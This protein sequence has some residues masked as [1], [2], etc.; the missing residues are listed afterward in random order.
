[1]RSRR[2]ARARGTPCI[3]N[4]VTLRAIL[5]PVVVALAAGGVLL[6]TTGPQECAA[7]GASSRDV[8]ARVGCGG[9]PT[10]CAADAGFAR[11][12][13]IPAGR[14]VRLRFTRR[15]RRAVTVEVFQSSIGGRVLGNRRIARF[16][17]R[18]RSFT[19][20]GRGA[21]DGY[22]F[23]RFRVRAA[24]GTDVRRS[25]LARRGGRFH[26][27]PA[28]YRRASCATLSQFK[29][30][31]PVFGGRG[32]RALGIAYRVSVPARVGVVVRRGKRV[33][34][35][36]RA[37]GVR[38]GRTVRLRLGSAKLRRGRYRVQATVTPQRGVATRASL[39]A[40]RL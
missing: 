9:G 25:V 3:H 1:M 31:Q 6:A 26:R 40:Q 17:R 22:L 11:A 28:F 24:G 8:E 15:V 27:R 2:P 35:R 4:A 10:A 39:S 20:D 38:P 34:R 30:R 29:L 23:V 16:T 32:Q 7:Q 37:R 12:S 19:W 13:A 36:F 14:R 33:V 18:K 5:P 21:R